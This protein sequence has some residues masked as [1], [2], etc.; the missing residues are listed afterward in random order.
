M[1][2]LAHLLVPSELERFGVDAITNIFITE[3]SDTLRTNPVEP[4][5]PMGY[6]MRMRGT[7]TRELFDRYANMLSAR[8]PR[9][10]KRKF[11]PRTH[12]AALSNHSAPHSTPSDHAAENA[13]LRQLLRDAKESIYRLTGRDSSTPTDTTPKSSGVAPP[14]YAAAYQVAPPSVATIQNQ[15]ATAPGQHGVPF[16]TRRLDDQRNKRNN[17]DEAHPSSAAPPRPCPAPTAT[18]REIT[19]FIRANRICFRH[20]FGMPCVSSAKCPYNHN[21]IP[22][23]YYKHLPRANKSVRSHESTP[24][25]VGHPR[26]LRRVRQC[27][28]LSRRSPVRRRR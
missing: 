5:C 4:Q 2:R 11:S 9:N 19:S 10:N 6:I 16:L 17:R 18:R 28:S 21:I 8:R 1:E 27:P 13:E 20:A 25:P 14:R 3:A 15:T 26:T 12:I 24:R 23:G 22:E 7:E